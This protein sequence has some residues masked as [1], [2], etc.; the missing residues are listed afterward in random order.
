MSSH[1]LEPL[2]PAIAELLEAERGRP[3]LSALGE[4]RVLARLEESIAR[5]APLPDL[6][7]PPRQRR[8]WLLPLGT[9]VAGLGLG[10]ALMGVALHR[11]APTVIAQAP[12][13]IAVPVPVPVPA[14]VAAP[15][16]VPAPVAAP[17]LRA[18]ARPLAEADVRDRELAA[19]RA[20]IETAR[21]AAQRGAGQATLEA[22]AAHAER[23]P[24]GRL[25]EERESLWVEAL[26]EAGRYP[27]ARQRAARF[28]ARFPSSLLGAAVDAALRSIPQ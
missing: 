16:P 17:V 13:P 19:E 15:L 22:L 3:G 1:D 4:R 11:A 12:D 28:H 2:D 23:F 25:A 6:E 8:R 7:P 14:P 5:G 9:F 26:V 21:T 27:E 20:L 18:P 24:R 10:G